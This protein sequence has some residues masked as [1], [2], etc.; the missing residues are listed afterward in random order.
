MSIH[1]EIAALI[2]DTNTDWDTQFDRVASRVFTHQFEHNAPYRQFCKGRGV[3]PEMVSSYLD[4]PAVPTDGFKHVRLTSSAEPVRTF[5]TSGT[6]VDK[7]GEHHFDTLDVYKAPIPGP[8][9]EFAM[10]GSKRLPMFVLAPSP[11]ELPDSSLSFMFGE[12]LPK[13]GHPAFSGFYI[14]RA[15]DG[16]LDF[17]MRDLVKALDLVKSPVFLLGTAFAFVELFD[18]VDQSWSL[19]EGSRVLETGG[20]KGRAR[21]I[22]RDELYALFTER[23]GVPPTHCI[24]EYSMTELSSQAYTDNLVQGIPWQDGWFD[25]PEWARVEVVDPVSLEP[26]PADKEREGLIRWYDLANVDSVLAV[27]TSDLGIRRPDGRFRL[28]GRASDAELRGCSLTIE[29]IIGK[30]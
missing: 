3:A 21:E 27:Q 28:L 11:S 23:L 2:G 24:S 6:T 15:D 22:S 8:F 17:A 19:P 16:E 10:A 20:L 26:L 30:E 4:V 12:L 18:A 25:L 13:F 1:T 5:R 29:E 7:R 9:R 14:H